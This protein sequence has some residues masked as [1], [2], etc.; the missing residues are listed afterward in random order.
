MESSSA[1]LGYLAVGG[2]VLVV[3]IALYFMFGRKKRGFRRGAGGPNKF[4]RL[5][6]PTDVD[7]EEQYVE[8]EPEEPATIGAK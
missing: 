1:N 7:L 4:A 6:E 8:E 2:I 3:V 5:E